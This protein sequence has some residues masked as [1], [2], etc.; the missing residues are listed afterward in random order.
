MHRLRA[1]GRAVA[2]GS[3]AATSAAFGAGSATADQTLTPSPLQVTFVPSEFA[4]HYEVGATDSAGLA[5]TYAWTL[6]PPTAD[7]ACNNH[8]NLTSSSNEFIWRHGDQDHCDH[9]KQGALGHLGIVSVVVSDTSSSCSASYGGT[10]GA[11]GSPTASVP[12]TCTALAGAPPLTASIAG[13][14][15]S[16]ATPTGAVPSSAASATSIAAQTSSGG[17]QQWIVVVLV[18]VGLVGLGILGWR[19]RRGHD[20]EQD[21]VY[22]DYSPGGGDD[23]V[24]RQP[25][26]PPVLPPLVGPLTPPVVGVVTTDDPLDTD[27]DDT[28]CSQLRARC[29]QLSAEA[30]QARANAAQAQAASTAAAAELAAATAALTAAQRAAAAADHPDPG[31]S[32]MEDAETG[33]RI[34]E[35]DL[36]LQ[37]TDEAATGEIH[38]DDPAHRAQLRQQERDR[39]HQALTAAQSNERAAHGRADQASVT[40]AAAQAAAATSQAEANAACAVADECDKAAA[41]AVTAS[42]VSPPVIP[43]V[44]PPVIPPVSPPVIPPVS[45]PVIPPV[46]PPVIPPTAS[47]PDCEDGC[48]PRVEEAS[49]DVQMFLVWAGNV[50]ISGAFQFSEDDVADALARFEKWKMIADIGEFVEGFAGSG[51]D[52]VS[53]HVGIDAFLNV[54][55]EGFNQ[56]NPFEWGNPIDLQGM[57]EDSTIDAL[58][59]LI[60]KVNPL[61]ILGTW[62]MSCPLVRVH[63][64]CT[65]TYECRGG[66]WVLTAHQFVVAYGEKI[67]DVTSPPRDNWDHDNPGRGAAETKSWLYRYFSNQNRAALQK[68]AQM[69][70]LCAAAK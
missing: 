52:L 6:T 68:I 70:K 63:V 13:T 24:E 44:S 42:P 31:E 22:P 5:I 25:L 21:F 1:V 14:P 3:L 16:A 30:A 60:A 39:A 11:N 67:R 51:G 66:Y 53:G 54:A 8:G 28:D 2:A 40:A 10:E 15:S 12:L 61:R 55:T 35:H 45:P 18:A 27:D 58:K 38:L 56:W 33:E 43:P 4:T 48:E 64:T 26:E 41:A 57:A 7:P 62:T 65:R 9:T 20:T 69:A 32:W 50:A 36:M 46:S 59:K 17:G 29:A 23:P 47:R 49:I 34:T 37:R 19:W